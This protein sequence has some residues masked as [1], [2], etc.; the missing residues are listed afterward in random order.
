MILR[1]TCTIKQNYGIMVRKIPRKNMFSVIAGGK[2]PLL[3]STTASIQVLADPINLEIVQ[4]A[5]V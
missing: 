1:I 4:K 5:I 2:Y 3:V